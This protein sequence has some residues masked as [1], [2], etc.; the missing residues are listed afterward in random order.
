MK[1]TEYQ[2]GFLN[3]K[4]HNTLKISFLSLFLTVQTMDI[5]PM[6]IMHT[7]DYS[8][9]KGNIN[10][11]AGFIIFYYI[12]NGI[13]QN[14]TAFGVGVADF[15]RL[16]GAAVEYVARPERIARDAVFGGRDDHAQPDIEVLAHDHVREREHG[17]GSAHVLFHDQHGA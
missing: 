4:I 17:R 8:P 13:G 9:Y 2:K 1:K 12:G 6:L 3:L 7:I 11:V 15:N 16:A 5:K 14:Q 10:Q